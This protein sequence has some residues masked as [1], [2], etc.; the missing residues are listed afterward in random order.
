MLVDMLQRFLCRYWRRWQ[1]RKCLR[2]KKLHSTAR[3]QSR[4]RWCSSIHKTS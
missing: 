1:T 4:T 2:S 3:F